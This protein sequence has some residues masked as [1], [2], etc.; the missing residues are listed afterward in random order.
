M[1]KLRKESDNPKQIL[2]LVND[3]VLWAK[4]QELEKRKVEEK[5][6]KERGMLG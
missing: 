2:K 4:H 6:E 3:R 5:K 1:E